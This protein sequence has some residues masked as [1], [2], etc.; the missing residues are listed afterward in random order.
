MIKA[1]LNLIEYFLLQCK[2]LLSFIFSEKSL[3]LALPVIEEYE[4]IFQ[5]ALFWALPNT[6]AGLSRC[7]LPVLSFF[8]PV[9]WALLKLMKVLVK[10]LILSVFLEED[11]P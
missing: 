10:S 9:I 2:L 5:L 11:I 8:M 7:Y 3:A 6:Q 4:F 1:C